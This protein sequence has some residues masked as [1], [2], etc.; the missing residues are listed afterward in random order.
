MSLS[1]LADRSG[2]LP[3]IAFQFLAYTILSGVT[4][5]LQHKLVLNPAPPTLGLST[6]KSNTVWVWVQMTVRHIVTACKSVLSFPTPPCTLAALYSVSQG[7]SCPPYPYTAGISHPC[8]DQSGPEPPFDQVLWIG[9]FFTGPR[10]LRIPYL[11]HPL[12]VCSLGVRLASVHSTLLYC[13]ELYCIVLYCIVSIEYLSTL[14]NRRT[15]LSSPF[16]SHR[17][18]QI[19]LNDNAFH[20]AY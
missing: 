19:E 2:T 17:S 18:Q 9:Y 3:T 7:L 4:S 8:L 14:L 11:D 5:I 6:G 1:L 12:P 16:P 15:V 10:I 13:I 20:F